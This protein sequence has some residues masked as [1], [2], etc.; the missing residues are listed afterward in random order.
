[1]ALGDLLLNVTPETTV[2]VLPFETKKHPLDSRKQISVTVGSLNTKF[3]Q[4]GHMDYRKLVLMHYRYYI[5]FSCGAYLLC[6]PLNNM[7]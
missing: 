6:Q 5:L 7:A 2:P 3:S 1:M 4:G